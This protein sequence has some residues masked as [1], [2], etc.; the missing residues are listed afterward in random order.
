MKTSDKWI[1][2]FILAAF[3]VA[4]AVH[5]VLYSEY[6]KG[7][8]VTPA[9]MHEEA[10]IKQPVHMPRILSFDGTIWVNLIPADSFSLELP[11]VNKDP[12]ASLFKMLPSI[13]MKGVNPDLPA[14]TYR[15]SG[16]TLFVTGNVRI[17][18][19]RPYS[20]WYY[21]RDIP[22]V[23]FYGPLPGNVLLNNGQLYLQGTADSLLPRSARFTLNNSTLWIGMQYDSRH[24]DSV[25]F[26]DSL[27]IRSANSIIV[28]NTAATIRHLQA[29]LRDSSVLTDQYARFTNPIIR[30][31][32]DSRIDIA[33]DA[34]KDNPMILH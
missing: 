3:F 10:F 26:F 28:L 18:L 34:I 5:G 17:A 22:Q 32:P 30:C 6:R 25:E 27:D 33:G 4:L 23:N 19:H 2:G 1:L 11:R 14:I 24:R 21:R 8:F 31:S 7:H 16:D 29:D 12:D 13:K 20:N 15:E 9:Q